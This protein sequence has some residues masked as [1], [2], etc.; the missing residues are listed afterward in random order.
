MQVASS[1]LGASGVSATVARTEQEYH[2]MLKVWIRKNVSEVHNLRKKFARKV[3]GSRLWR[4]DIW[5]KVSTHGRDSP[6]LNE[7]PDEVCVCR[8]G[9][10]SS[11]CGGIPIVRGAT[12]G[13]W[14]PHPMMNQCKL[15][16]LNKHLS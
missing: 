6:R 12:S 10:C 4:Y 14:L 7:N 16:V 9:V 11:G 15:N 8:S 13:A 3:H 5:A 1:L 2:D